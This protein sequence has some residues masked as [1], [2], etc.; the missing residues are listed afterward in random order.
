MFQPGM[1]NLN[2]MVLPNLNDEIR[3]LEY[4]YLVLTH[5]SVYDVQ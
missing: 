1:S 5:S 4:T 3:A 2:A